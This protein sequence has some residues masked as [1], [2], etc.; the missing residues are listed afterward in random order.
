MQL[1]NTPQHY[2]A[3]SIVIHWAM[4]VLIVGLFILGR[5]EGVV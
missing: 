4:A 2:G 1:R 3:I 5:S